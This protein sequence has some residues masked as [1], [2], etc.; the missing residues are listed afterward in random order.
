MR[1]LILVTF[2]IIAVMALPI[3]PVL[4]QTPGGTTGEWRG[5]LDEPGTERFADSALYGY[6]EF[7]IASFFA[8][9]GGRDAG[10]VLRGETVRLSPGTGTISSGFEPG[11]P[12]A[13]ARGCST[14]G[15]LPVPGQPSKPVTY[16]TPGRP[17]L[18]VYTYSAA[19]WQLLNSPGIQP[20]PVGGALCTFSP[21]DGN[22]YRIGGINSSVQVINDVWRFDPRTGT[23]FKLN[24]SGPTFPFVADGGAFAFGKYLGIFAGVNGSFTPTNQLWIID[25]EELSTAEL[26]GGLRPS[27]RQTSTFV[28]LRATIDDFQPL[29]SPIRVIVHGGDNG[30]TS[31]G[32]AW[33]IEASAG[34]GT[35]PGRVR[36]AVD[37]LPTITFA[38]VQTSGSRPPARDS[39]VAWFNPEPLCAGRGKMYIHGGISRSPAGAQVLKDIWELALSPA[40]GCPTPTPTT[41]GTLTPLANSTPTRTPTVAPS[42]SA[43]PTR[44]VTPT[45]TR[46]PQTS[47][48]G[49]RGLALSSGGG[50]VFLR[51]LDG[52]GQTGYLVARLAGGTLSFLPTSGPLDPNSTSFSD[53]TAP[54]GLDCYAVLPLGTN[55]QLVSDLECAVMGFHTPTGS[56]RQLHSTPEPVQHGNLELGCSRWAAHDGY[57]LVT[58]GGSTETLPSTTLSANLPTNGFSCYVVGALNGSALVG[59]SDVLCGQPGFST[60]GSP[61]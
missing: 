8:F 42:A 12:P 46:N 30:G 5:I 50:G 16:F 2:A 58:L 3:G 22:F 27:P 33:T 19:G 24:L 10:Q 48:P 23:W 38:Q 7:R 17:L 47:G 1:S 28:D 26:I 21:F 56:P 34:P 31:L 57:L 54:P 36:S 44:T 53:N 35:S 40:G 13:N 20:P 52:I 55:P 60:L 14:P 51:W 59:Y 11:S 43:T 61:T 37:A 25:L 9:F 4:A 32:D 29:V 18:G 45:L 49:G 39:H 41:T 15:L 6:D